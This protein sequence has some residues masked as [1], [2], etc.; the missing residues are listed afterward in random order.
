MHQPDGGGEP[1]PNCAGWGFPKKGRQCEVFG[2][3][4]FLTHWAQQKEA[5]CSDR[6]STLG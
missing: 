3:L 2:L 1:S 5:T 4:L 6:Q